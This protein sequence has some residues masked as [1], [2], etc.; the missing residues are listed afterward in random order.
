[1]KVLVST[2]GSHGD[3]LP[4][5]AIGR[6][7][8]ARGHES[9]LFAN[10][11]FRDDVTAA[12]LQFVPIGTV[13]EYARLCGELAESDPMKA[14]QRVS[15]HFAEICRNYYLAMKAEVV[16][17][18]TIAMGSSLLFASRLLRET[19]G[20]LCAVVH[21]APCV[22]RSN[23]KPARLV[24]NWINSDTPMPLKRAAWWVADKF[25]YDRYFT[26]PLNALR[27]ELGLAP[28][29]DVLRSWIHEAD[30]AVALFPEWFAPRQ[31]DWPAHAVL[32]GFPLY[33]NGE[34]SPLPDQLV[35]FLEAGPAPVA[36]SAGTANAN[37]K[38][39][40]ET[41][42]AAC[43]LAGVRGVL[44][45]H[46]ADQIPEQCPADIMHVAYAPF[47][48]LLPKL[49]AFVHHGGIGSISQALRAGVPQLI[50]PVAYDQFDNSACA[51]RLGVAREL[52][53]K[54]YSAR[55]VADALSQ[56]M[57]DIRVRERCSETASRFVNGDGIQAA[58]DAILSRCAV[59]Q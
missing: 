17:E 28:V 32:T 49:A 36:F 54:Q 42:L 24:P 59:A 5:I 13:D 45:S 39:F 38:S 16:A 31:T 20:V 40:F 27:S 41:S 44:I 9:V 15:A 51:V 21:L 1:M 37:A 19:D 34:R 22:F 50:R 46:F 52:L 25:Y 55:S 56:L 35:E 26:K 53:P 8:R 3:V 29:A 58:C 57:S 33:D 7:M 12:G 23:L 6:E 4:Y 14:L 18:Q 2:F 47:G 48:A 10:P 11:Y 43:R 30:C